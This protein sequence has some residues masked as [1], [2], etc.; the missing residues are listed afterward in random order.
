MKN[1]ITIQERLAYSWAVQMSVFFRS[2]T[3]S[4]RTLRR[5]REAA[6]QLSDLEALDLLADVPYLEVV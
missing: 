3:V 6:Y 1:E 2:L 5:C 4:E